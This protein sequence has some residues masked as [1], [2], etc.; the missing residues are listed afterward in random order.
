[1]IRKLLL[2][3]FDLNLQASVRQQAEDLQASVMQMREL[4]KHFWAATVETDAGHYDVEVVITPARIK[5][6]SCTCFFSGRRSMCPH[7]AATLLKVRSFLE[8]K[9]TEKRILSTEKTQKEAASSHLTPKA[10]I[11]A[12]SEQDLRDFLLEYARR[13][14]DFALALKV[15]FA[16]Q[17]NTRE[18]PWEK[19]LDTALP[20][21]AE[22]A[23]PSDW[24]RFLNTANALQQHQ[25]EAV[26]QTDW[27]EAVAIN[28]ALLSKLGELRW[29][30]KS[31]GKQGIESLFQTALAQL[32]N[33]PDESLSPELR[34]KVWQ[35]I[36]SLGQEGKLAQ[37]A[38]TVVVPF[39]AR[40]AQETHYFDAIKQSFQQS[41]DT[42]GSFAQ[43]T[44][45]AAMLG[46]NLP[47]AAL[48]VW[49]SQTP[50][51][52]PQALAD[53]ILQWA[54]WLPGEAIS[55]LLILALKQPDWTPRQKTQIE[56]ALLELA[57]KLNDTE[58][59]ATVFRRRF[60]ETA[61]TS[62]LERL[63]DVSGAQWPEVRHELIFVLEKMEDK[64]PLLSLY[65]YEKNIEKLIEL[66][67]QQND[68]KLIQRIEDDLLEF[69]P[70]MV[71]KAYQRRLVDYLS[72][73]FGAPSLAWVRLQLANLLHKGQMDMVISLMRFL[74]QH[75]P[76]RQALASELLELFPKSKRKG[77][78]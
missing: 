35:L 76:E 4:E 43:T 58:A 20:K 47:E 12:A 27:S 64:A 50:T 3:D 75:F 9:Q 51:L 67:E 10:I 73:H 16:R 39:M 24:K 60:Q 74:V 42:S 54:A 30:Q 37:S 62:W 5:E 34:E 44:L 57:I 28:S 2:E 65:F 18:Q 68:L 19:L 29:P 59:Q 38:L 61:Q 17:M 66:L 56:N 25:A 53:V 31:S 8:Q 6:F 71:F 11:Q 22:K 46:R 70:E 78:F 13:D 40:K 33:L 48:K 21:H 41:G 49:E 7:I 52:T 63:R 77:I 69:K 1:M 32:T 45:I 55:R 72:D 15:R 23:S 26:K 14:V 36:M